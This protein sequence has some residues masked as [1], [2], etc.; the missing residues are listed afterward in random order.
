ML[1]SLA[2]GSARG[3]ATKTKGGKGKRWSGGAEQQSGGTNEMGRSKA[4]RQGTK[5]R[6]TVEVAAE[7]VR[8]GIV[9]VG[10]EAESDKS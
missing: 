10:G 7:T 6:R 9:K 4:L 1:R 2:S 5:R 3:R 8:C